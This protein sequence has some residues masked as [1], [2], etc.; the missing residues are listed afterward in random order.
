MNTNLKEKVT[1]ALAHLSPTVA[2]KWNASA[3]EGLDPIPAQIQTLNGFLRLQLCAIGDITK[4]TVE[5]DVARTALNDSFGVD[6]WLSE[7][8]QHVLPVLVNHWH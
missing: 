2:V 5:T 8:K 3:P 7:L 6:E 4:Y 1:E